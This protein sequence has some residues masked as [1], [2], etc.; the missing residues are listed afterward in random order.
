MGDGAYHKKRLLEYIT[1][2]QNTKGAK[3]I[4]P[5]KQSTKSYGNRLKVEG[6][7]NELLVTNL[8]HRIF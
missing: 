2:Q 4:G 3:F 7:I 1:Q 8:K 6:D 5:P